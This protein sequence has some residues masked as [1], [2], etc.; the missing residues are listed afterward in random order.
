METSVWPP[1]SCILSANKK[2]LIFNAEYLSHATQAKGLLYLS[3]PLISL[4]FGEW[5]S[6]TY[7]LLLLLI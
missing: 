6:F 7:I 3:R 5:C 2:T 4:L 1:N